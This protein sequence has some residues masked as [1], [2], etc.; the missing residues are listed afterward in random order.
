MAM[1]KGKVT[2]LRPEKKEGR[3]GSRVS[4]VVRGKRHRVWLLAEF[5]KESKFAKNKPIQVNLI[6]GEVLAV[7]G[8][9]PVET[10]SLTN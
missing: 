9:M 4:M 8:C 2:G 3:K 1:V 10:Q 5:V 6:D 7:A